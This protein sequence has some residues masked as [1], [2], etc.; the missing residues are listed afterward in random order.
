MVGYQWRQFLAPLDANLQ[1]AGE[2]GVE[3][4]PPGLGDSGVRD[5]SGQGMLD[6]ILT[7]A[8][9]A[10]RDGDAR[11]P[12]SSSPMSGLSPDTSSYTGRSRT[13]AR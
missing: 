9:Q 7:F 6:H 12:P 13:C 8:L 4:R 3:P 5:F 2:G 1:P 11:S 10:D